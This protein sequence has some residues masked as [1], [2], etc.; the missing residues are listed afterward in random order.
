[1]S[2][3]LKNWKTHGKKSKTRINQNNKNKNNNKKKNNN[4]KKKKG[5]KENIPYLKWINY[6]TKWTLKK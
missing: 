1:M 4:N 2:L 3:N 5:I 6:Q